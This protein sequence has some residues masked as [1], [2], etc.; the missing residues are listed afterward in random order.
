MVSSIVSAALLR[1]A[2]AL[3]LH[4][5]A[6]DP[7]PA[8]PTEQVAVRSVAITVAAADEP[9]TR[10][11][12][13]LGE[14]LD[15]LPARIAIARSEGFT[16]ARVIDDE[17]GD[18]FAKVWIDATQREHTRIFIVDRGADRILIR[19]VQTPTGL[20]EVAVD[21]IAYIVEASVDALLRGGTL[22][23]T[24]AVAAAE[25]GVRRPAPSVS[26]PRSIPPPRRW[27]LALASSYLGRGW[28]RGTA[29]HG[30]AIEVAFWRRT[31]RVD[32]GA[33]IE[34]AAILPTRVRVDDLE[35]RLVGGGVR[36]LAHVAGPIA[37]RWR[38]DGR[39]GP[40][41][42]LVRDH[43]RPRA[44]GATGSPAVTRPIAV[45]AVRTGPS[46]AIGRGRDR[47][48]VR[49]HATLDIELAGVRYVTTEGTAVLVP[50]RAR[51]GAA[52]SIGW[53]REL[54]AAPTR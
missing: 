15:A 33:A 21:E 35:L 17:G 22:G 23:V 39:L 24:R 48:L 16:A 19:K 8:A 25:L 50:W 42:D 43:G 10:L 3:A 34:G 47:L 31:D 54:I 45:L 14:F 53:T 1:L 36:A 30:P 27:A 26:P 18:A 2:L 32:A 5:D 41:L 20:D 49:L 37:R 7:T 6:G 52:L 44:A 4:V 13:R 29:Q 28:G 51:P 12:E 40:G 46:L 38:W 9:G 11:A